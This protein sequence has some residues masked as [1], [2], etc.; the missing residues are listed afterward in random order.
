M[1][2]N[3]AKIEKIRKSTYDPSSIEL[4]WQA[5]WEK[6]GTYQPDLDA[7]SSSSV[8]DQAK[9]HGSESAAELKKRT[10]KKGQPFYNLMMFPYPSAEGLHVGSMYAFG[11]ADIYGRFKRMMG[12]DVFEPIG[13]DG[14]GIHSEN[15]AIKTNTHPVDHAK[16]TQ[17]NFYRQLHAIGNSYAWDNKVE[18]YD[19]DYYRWTQW[20]FVQLFK[21]GLAYKKNSPV[22][23]CPSCK[24]VLS[25]E[26]VIDGKCERCGSVVE[27][28]DLEQ[29]FFRITNYAEKLLGNI[30]KLD[31]SERV[32]LAQKNWIGKKEG[33]NITYEIA[34]SNQT[35]TIFTTRP[36]T[37][38]G[39]TFIAL[40][41]EHELVSK[42][43]KGTITT[44]PQIVKKI[45]TYV[46]K[47]LNKSEIDR[48]AEG[49]EKSGVFTGLY[50]INTLTGYQMPVWVSDFVLG[51]FGTGALV[52]VPGH[53]KRDFEFAT[54]FGLEII[55]VVVGKDGDASPITKIEQVQ[56]AD[57][58]M[59]NS[60]F[61]NGLDIHK[62]TE[63]IMDYLEEKGYGKR[64]VTYHLRDWLISRQRYWGPPIPMIYCEACAKKKPKILLIHG[65]SGS[66]EE[67]WFPWFKQLVEE[68]G[69]E[70]LIPDLPNADGPTL[71]E[72][73]T[74]LKKFG[75]TKEDRLTV[76]AHS[77]GAPTAIEFIRQTR[78]QVEKL[79][80]VAPTGKEQKEANWKALRKEGL[81]KGVDAIKT[82]N[83]VNEG[84]EEIAGL[85]EKTVLYLSDNDP[86]IPLTV[87]NSYKGLHPEVK[88]FKNHGHFSAGAD[89]LEF[90]TILN[91]FP[92]VEEGNLGWV[93]V[94]EEDLP[95][96]L[97]Y[98]KNFKPLGTGKAPL[99]NHSEFYETTCPRC[100]GKA[101]RET[102]VSDTFLDSSWYFLRYLATDLQ[103][104]PFPMSYEMASK[105]GKVKKDEVEKADK[106]LAWLPVTSYIGGAEHSVLHL[107][108]ARFITMALKDMGYVE[109][110]EPFSKFYAHGLIIKDGAK[111]SKSKGNVI[112]PDDYIHKYGADALRTYLLFLGPFNQGGDFRDSG[113]D[114]MSR[115]LKRVWKL[116]TGSERWEVG[117]E[118]FEER[119]HMMHMTIKGITEDMENLRFNTA[120]AKLMTYYNFL[121][122]QASLTR[123]EVEVYLKLL[124]PFAPHM[125][126][127]LYQGL[128]TQDEGR[129]FFSIHTS[130]WPSYDEKYLKVDTVTIAVQVNGKLRATLQVSV[131]DKANKEML[132][133]MASVDEHVKKFIETGV[134]KVILVPGKILNF[135]V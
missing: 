55:R 5:K 135:V 26:Q 63:R 81:D 64:E 132:E 85:V 102:D 24:T 75:I 18:T 65:L 23:F 116:F 104:L 126:E 70:V 44:D 89:I 62:A 103:D 105:F 53:D 32:K 117:S 90:P 77:L 71:Q 74:V 129:G 60:D 119:L 38:F 66:S 1:A 36:D 9:T 124:A 118:K 133:K 68:K 11:G 45:Q 94:P 80:L 96:K 109:F 34:N 50:A 84:L 48:V 35:V 61:L 46:E 28:R 33:I 40:A 15:H 7:A 72:W 127:E 49:K 69:Y 14:F 98:I 73:I 13:L 110:E 86:Y 59:I 58:T 122:K 41:P 106:R 97:P 19:S 3:K 12:Y 29:W 114:G 39:A 27:K 17:E 91:E 107:L 101:I 82:F 99:A 51:G 4:K 52:G 76:V 108:Y 30:E 56:E 8:F 120:I 113:I 57:G 88:I 121:A 67:N 22:N 95:V 100:G 83:K 111:M 93:P 134:K 47:A 87:E 54:K 43:L 16:R 2:E 128:G 112:N 92:S 31:W 10:I 78:L 130:Q 131:A 37:N 123:D 6:E 115:F 20:I 79:I 42:L 21:S 25:D 125:T